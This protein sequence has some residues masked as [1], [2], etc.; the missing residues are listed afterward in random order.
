LK[1]SRVGTG[2]AA[3][4]PEIQFPSSKFNE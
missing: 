1:T 4:M 3:T 2:E